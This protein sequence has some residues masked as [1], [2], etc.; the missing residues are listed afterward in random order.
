[1]KTYF[2][3]LFSILHLFSILESRS[4]FFSWCVETGISAGRILSL[5]GEKPGFCDNFQI[6]TRDIGRNPV[7]GISAARIL[8]LRGEK[9]G[10]YEDFRLSTINQGRNPVSGIMKNSE[11]PGFCDNLQLSTRNKA[12]NPVSE[13][14]VPPKSTSQITSQSAYPHKDL[15]KLAAPPKP[16]KNHQSTVR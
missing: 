9:P 11:K 15:A 16:T 10:F 8:S 3:D 4:I 5:R 1:M 7:S 12:R 14:I 13:I 6:S 2:P